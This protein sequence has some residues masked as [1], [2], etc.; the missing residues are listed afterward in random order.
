MASHGKMIRTERN[1]NR[2]RIGTRQAHNNKNKLK[3][4][5]SK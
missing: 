2:E 5:S 1:E 3:R 4:A